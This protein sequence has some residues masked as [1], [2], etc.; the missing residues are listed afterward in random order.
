M[1]RWASEI[2]LSS[3][4]SLFESVSMINDNSSQKLFQNVRLRNNEFCNYSTNNSV[5]NL[6][7]M[8]F[9][10]S[11]HKQVKTN[12]IKFQRFGHWLVFTCLCISKS[13]SISIQAIL[14]FLRHGLS[15]DHD[16]RTSMDSGDH[17]WTTGQ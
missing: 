1:A 10:N 7:R 6:T 17:V 14:F 15:V 13:L 2:S 9:V 4:V 11:S 3:L 5:R 16:S 12:Q 8:F